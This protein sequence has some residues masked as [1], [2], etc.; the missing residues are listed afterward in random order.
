MLTTGNGAGV[1]VVG[2]PMI[3][4]GGLLDESLL[5]A[6]VPSRLG[7]CEIGIIDYKSVMRNSCLVEVLGVIVTVVVIHTAVGGKHTLVVDLERTRIVVLVVGG[8]A[9]LDTHKHRRR[10]RVVPGCADDVLTEGRAVILNELHSLVSILCGL[11][12]CRRG[13]SE[14]YRS[15]ESL[16][17]GGECRALEVGCLSQ[18][19]L[20]GVEICGD[21]G[22]IGKCARLLSVA[23]VVAV[24]EDHAGRVFIS[25]EGS[26]GVLHTDVGVS[27]RG[28]LDDPRRVEIADVSCGCVAGA[29]MC[30]ARPEVVVTNLDVVV[31]DFCRDVVPPR[32][33]LIVDRGSEGKIISEDLILRAVSG[34]RALLRGWEAHLHF[35]AAGV[36]ATAQTVLNACDELNLVLL[37]EKIVAPVVDQ[38]RCEH[39]VAVLSALIGGNLLYIKRLQEILHIVNCL[40]AVELVVVCQICQS[41]YLNDLEVVVVV[42][43]EVRGVDG[44]VLALIL[45]RRENTLVLKNDVEDLV[46]ALREGV[47]ICERFFERWNHILGDEKSRVLIALRG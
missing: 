33:I 30:N 43:M 26:D 1:V 24:G 37:G 23:A 46:E 20:V 34:Y 27:S 16:E 40:I 9:L 19:S 4:I 25:E 44:I 47:I 5:T 39:S 35:C 29:L 3:E 13:K 31:A 28:D 42:I 12:V 10:C 18:H 22:H 15:R 11:D 8:G 14:E 6:G 41:L 21:V 32:G 2:E 38:R 45:G 7:V 17:V 36:A